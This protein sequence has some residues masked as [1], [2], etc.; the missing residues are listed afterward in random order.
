MKPEL[1]DSQA[2]SVELTN[3]H[4]GFCWRIAAGAVSVMGASFRGCR[5]LTGWRL[6]SRGGM[7]GDL[8]FIEVDVL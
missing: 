5:Q 2:K 6:R 3:A 7:R 1:L 4:P 8:S